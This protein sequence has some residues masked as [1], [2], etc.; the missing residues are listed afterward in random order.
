MTTS[1]TLIWFSIGALVSMLLSPFIESVFIQVMIFAIVAIVWTGDWKTDGKSQDEKQSDK[2][3][4]YGWDDSY[5]DDIKYSNG[6]AHYSSDST[7]TAT[8]RFKGT[9]VD[10]Y[11][12][13]NGKVGKVFATL[14]KVEKDSNG[15]ETFKTIL[16][17]N[18]DNLAE[19]GDK[20]ETLALY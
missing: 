6:S 5:K 8:F 20:Y 19:S 12:R 2:N 3:S 7:A 15:K 10:I 17:K 11:S 14:E 1:L 18:I 9:G 13:T 4:Q 16:M